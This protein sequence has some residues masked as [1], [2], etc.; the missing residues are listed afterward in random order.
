MARARRSFES[1]RSARGWLRRQLARRR[2]RDSHRRHAGV[3]RDRGGARRGGRRQNARCPALGILARRPR[4][5]G[6]RAKASR[7]AR[8]SKS[9][10]AAGLEL[11]AEAPFDRLQDARRSVEEVNIAGLA[12][13]RLTVAPVAVQPIR[14]R[15]SRPSPTFSARGRGHARS[16]RCRAGPIPPSRPPATT[17]SSASRSRVVVVDNVRIDPGG[18]GAATAPSWRRWR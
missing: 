12:L 11:V 17:T 14:C 3:A 8:C 16:R 7:F 15:C 1:P 4:R 13:A 10:S 5:T 9:C 6:G 18:L 2:G